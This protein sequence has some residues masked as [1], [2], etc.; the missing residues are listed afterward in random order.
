MS[1]QQ[2]LG[3]ISPFFIVRD[4]P[5][6]V[7]FY[8]QKLD[9]EVR[10]SDP[11]TPF[12]SIVGRDAVQILLKDVSDKVGPQVGPQPN[13][14]RHEW[15]PWDAYVFVDDPDALATEFGSCAVNFHREIVDRGDGLR[16]FEVCDCDGYVLFFGRP[17]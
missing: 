12:F 4:I 1:E 11:E 10:F 5:R 14:S 13:H 2:T 8:T 7:E 3:P 6:A 17:R 15:A 9:F 16:G